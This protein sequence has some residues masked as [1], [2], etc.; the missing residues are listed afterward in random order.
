MIVNS[1]D[2]LGELEFNTDSF[3]IPAITAKSIFAVM[4]ANTAATGSNKLIPIV[5]N[6]TTGG[7][8][9]IFISNNQSPFNG[10]A[11]SLD[12]NASDQGSWY[13]NGTFKASGGNLITTGGGNFGDIVNGETMLQ[14]IIYTTAGDPATTVTTIGKQGDNT[15][16]NG[17][18]KELIIY[19]S[20]KSANLPA[21]EAN[22]NN[23]HNIYS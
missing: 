6:T 18:F 5:S 10:Y 1:G 14:T 23:Q 17:T 7:K 21:I 16:A 20:D 4:S 8:S 2:Y 15:Q 19:S 3:E 11:I 22:I 9:Y 12:G 13:L